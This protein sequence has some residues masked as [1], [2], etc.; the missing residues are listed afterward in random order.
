MKRVLS[1]REHE[2]FVD[3]FG[4]GSDEE[5]KDDSLCISDD[6]DD[7]VEVLPPPPS[8]DKQSLV[9]LTADTS[10]S[11][12][13]SE[14]CDNNTHN[15]IISKKL[16]KREKHSKHS[17]IEKSKRKASRE[18]SHEHSE[19]KK[20]KKTDQIV[21]SSAD[22]ADQCKELFTMYERDEP[23]E[24]DSTDAPPVC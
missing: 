22:S 1:K 17:A 20:R 11:D 6:E 10:S 19:P 13:E 4:D 24:D 18:N 12:G 9:D 16:V 3:L 21:V 5:V 8:E 7:V 2:E 15:I 23:M 14:P